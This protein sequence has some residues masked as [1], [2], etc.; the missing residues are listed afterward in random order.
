MQNR[1]TGSANRKVQKQ[2]IVII[3]T[4]A[5][6]CVLFTALNPDFIKPTN[7]L[8]ILL[9]CVIVGLMA[10]GE[11]MCIIAGYFDLSVGM[12]ASL[13]GLALAFVLKATHS[14][15][16]SLVCGFAVGGICGLIAGFLVSYLHMNAFI[17]TFALQSIYRGIIY[18]LT[19]GL[20]ISLMGDEYKRFTV[21]GQYKLFGVIQLPI[22]ILI[23]VY[24][25]ATLFMKYRRLGRKIY[26][27]GGNPRCAHISGV[28]LHSIHL[29]VF[30]VCDMLASLAGILYASRLATAQPFLSEMVAMEAIAASV[31]GGISLMGGKG[32]IAMTFLG[33]LVI[34]VV[35]NG[36]TMI[37]MPDFYQYIATG[38][39]LYIA[40]LIQMM[41]KTN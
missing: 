28:S 23:L 35:K 33:V 16:L 30:I 18:I 32:N 13:S 5:L 9:T 34:Y 3:L 24:I 15:F 7:L 29:F 36:L 14:L 6:L 27:T 38:A 31:V 19:N 17:T 2:S 4:L 10:V 37:G 26:L 21:I 41:K 8:S 12:V 22:L 25:I 39:I 11:S 20:S 40:V 1:I